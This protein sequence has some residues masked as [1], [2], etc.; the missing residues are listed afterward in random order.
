MKKMLL[1]LFLSISISSINA[2]RM[3]DV[4]LNDVVKSARVTGYTAL[5]NMNTALSAVENFVDKHPDASATAFMATY[6]AG[7][8]YIFI[9]SVRKKVRNFKNRVKSIITSTPV[10]AASFGFIGGILGSRYIK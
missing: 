2:K 8:C 9:P 3:M 10:Q 1:I 6:V 5:N 4:T 7:V